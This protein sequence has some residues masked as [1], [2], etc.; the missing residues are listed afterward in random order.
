VAV[1]D[2]GPDLGLIGNPEEL[3]GGELGAVDGFG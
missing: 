2:G 1:N 3:L